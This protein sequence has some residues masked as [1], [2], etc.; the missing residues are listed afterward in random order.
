MTKKPDSFETDLT[1]KPLEIFEEKPVNV[2][3]AI[4]FE[5]VS[6]QYRLHHEPKMTLQDWAVS[7][8]NRKNTYEDFWALKNISFELQK[9]KTLGIIGRNGA[10]KSTLLK[11]ATRVVEPTEG[12]IRV[13]GRVSAMLELGTGFHHDLTARDNIYLN[14]AFYGYNRKQMDERY[15]QILEFSELGKFIDTPVKHFSSGMYMRL[16]FAIAI[17]VEPDILIIDEVLSVGDAA[18][19]R[20]CNDAIAE[21]KNQSKAMMFVSHNPSDIHYYCDEAIYLANGQVVMRGKPDDVLADYD[22]AGLERKYFV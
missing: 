18:F 5:S 10:G 9:G 8:F 13:N 14:G 21:M 17:T 11:L 15:E 19:G 12:V 4:E 20:K 1:E 16:G 22:A 6:R 3:N 2:G 7:F